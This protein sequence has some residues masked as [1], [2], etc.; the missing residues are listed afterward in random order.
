[1]VDT[2][3]LGTSV[4][5]RAHVNRR[6]RHGARR[7]TRRR[8]ATSGAVRLGRCEESARFC[9]FRAQEQTR[10]GYVHCGGEGWRP[11]GA[12][13]P[14]FLGSIPGSATAKGGAVKFRAYVFFAAIYSALASLP[15]AWRIYT[16]GFLWLFFGVDMAIEL[17]RQRR[18]RIRDAAY[19][20]SNPPVG[21][22][23]RQCDVVWRSATAKGARLDSAE[24]TKD[25]GHDGPHAGVLDAEWTA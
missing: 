3:G 2:V 15:L 25:L 20:A 22:H 14:G 24:C 7:G 19:A 9:R 16:A 13:T 6:S 1:M 11:T 12:H 4:V 8:S 5:I 10:A 17:W 18:Q 23:W 21:S